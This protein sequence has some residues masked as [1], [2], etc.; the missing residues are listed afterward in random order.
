MSHSCLKLFTTYSRKKEKENPGIKYVFKFTM[1]YS[2]AFV[3]KENML[4]KLA[5]KYRYLELTVFKHPVTPA[6]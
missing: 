6:L 5:F 3:T 4:K 1:I 2:G